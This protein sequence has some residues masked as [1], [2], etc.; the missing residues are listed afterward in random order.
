[1]E[2]P[3]TVKGLIFLGVKNW[4]V[5]KKTPDDFKK[6]VQAF[7]PAEQRYWGKSKLMPASRVPASVY[8]NTYR[9]ICSQMDEATF[10]RIAGTVAFNDLGTVFRIFIKLGTPAFTANSFPGAYRQ[11]FNVGKLNS[12]RVTPKSAEFELTQG[13]AY[14]EAGCSGT[15]GWTRRALEYAGAKYLRADHATCRYHGGDRCLFRYTWE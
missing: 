14:G 13:E 15:L 12:I 8:V 3:A 5:E 2:S 4:F 1:V 7:P 10:Q 11:Y 9:I 6:F